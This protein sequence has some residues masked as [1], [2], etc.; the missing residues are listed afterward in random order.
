MPN[1]HSNPAN[2]TAAP[3]PVPVLN[4]DFHQLVDLLTPG[5]FGLDGR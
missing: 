2:K 4:G 3:K 1:A 5:I